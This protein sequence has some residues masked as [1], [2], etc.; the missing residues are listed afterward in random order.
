MSASKFS[1]FSGLLVLLWGSEVLAQECF[2]TGQGLSESRYSYNN[3]VVTD[4]VTGL[5]WSRC[6]YGHELSGDYCT[7]S[8]VGANPYD[9]WAQILNG[10][11]SVNDSDEPLGGYTGWR[12][13]S[14]VEMRSIIDYTCRAPVVNQTV[15][16]LGD[17]YTPFWTS[18]TAQR[19]EEQAGLDSYGHAWYANLISGEFAPK[20]KGQSG[21]YYI[22]F[23]VRDTSTSSTSEST[24]SSSSSTSSTT[25]TTT[26][27]TT[28]SGTSTTSSS[29]SD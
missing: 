22:A 11:D 12:M 6:P 16:P 4:T 18:T 24:S 3:E 29:T 27:A 1:V 9:T 10:I 19:T 23:M 2:S 21:G 8:S 13:P 17:F 25:T 28:T 20:L 5:M 26:T 7:I 14:I 15:F